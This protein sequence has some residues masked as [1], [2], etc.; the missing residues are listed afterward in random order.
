MFRWLNRRAAL[1]ALLAVSPACLNPDISDEY[2]LSTQADALDVDDS[3]EAIDESADE[4]ALTDDDAAD[5]EAADD[6]AEPDA[7]EQDER[8]S[9]A[10]ARARPRRSGSRR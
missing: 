9:N 1:A 10:D 7:V 4:E 3:G 5:D 6:D 8:A 2:P